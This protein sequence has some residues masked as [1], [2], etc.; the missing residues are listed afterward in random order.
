MAK[1]TKGPGIILLG[2]LLLS[3]AVSLWS[4]QET[5][6]QYPVFTCDERIHDFGNIREIESFAMHEFVVKNTGPAPLVIEYVLSSCGCAQ[7][8]WSQMPIEP[9]EEGFVIVTYD[10]KDR[11]GPFRK[12]FTVFTNERS[13]RQILTIVGD[14]IPKPSTLNVLFHDTI[15]T[16]QMERNK[17]MFYTALPQEIK[18]TEIWIQ[19]FGEEDVNVVI[20][21]VPEYINVTVPDRLISDYP[22][23]MK[24]VLDATKVDEKMRGRLLSQFTWKEVT[25]SGQTMT[26]SIPISVNFIDDFSTMTPAEKEDSPSIQFSTTFLE[27]GKLKSRRV[28]KEFSITNTGQSTLQLHSITADN[29][30]AQITGFKKNMLKPAETQ[31]LRVYVNPKDFTDHFATDLIVVCNDPQKPVSGVSILAEK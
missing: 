25:A 9:G 16:V 26:H 21:D 6:T 8:E 27:Y 24:V 17:F 5:E 4:Q 20:E 3:H 10:M 22:E 7:P 29:P 28:Y 19:N 11:P 1:K 12:N 31:K 14:V 18:E 30:K 23:R 15:G 2:F 13:L